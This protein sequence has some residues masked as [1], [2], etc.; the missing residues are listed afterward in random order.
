MT[1]ITPE[2]RRAALAELRRPSLA[3]DRAPSF[4]GNGGSVAGNEKALGWL[5]PTPS[6]SA[7]PDAMLSPL[8]KECAKWNREH[9]AEVKQNI[10]RYCR[11]NH[12][13]RIGAAYDAAR[14]L[15]PQPQETSM[16]FH[17]RFPMAPRI[18]CMDGNGGS[19]DPRGDP[20]N[21]LISGTNNVGVDNRRRG[22]A[23]DQDPRNPTGM[24]TGQT[25]RSGLNS[26]GRDQEQDPDNG[27]QNGGEPFTAD[28]LVA[29]FE[30]ILQRVSPPMRA[31]IVGKLQ[32][33]LAGL[34]HMNGGNGN[35]NGRDN[36]LQGGTSQRYQGGPG[37][38][39]NDPMM[40]YNTPAGRGGMLNPPPNGDRSRSGYRSGRTAGDQRPAMDVAARIEAD[41]I[42]SFECRWGN[43][44]RHINIG[45]MPR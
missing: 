32:V 17:E 14:G 36:G 12:P 8:A 9:M 13:I 3:F 18:I 21:G 28:D 11:P 25:F 27:E 38:S 22:S 37:S 5:L 43:L 7:D 29:L 44:T 34:E 35:G 41:S 31:Q 40:A 6:M 16:G 15:R 4:D 1:I 45:G 10:R 33:M 24:S 42:A 26:G 19:M 23:R 20:V 39:R 2:L 30:N